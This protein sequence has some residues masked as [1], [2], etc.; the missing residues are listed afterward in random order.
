ME[1]VSLSLPLPLRC[2]FWLNPRA[3][4]S[5]AYPCL[6][7]PAPLRRRPL[8]TPAPIPASS[9]APPD[10]LSEDGALNALVRQQLPVTATPPA[11]GDTASED[12]AAAAQFYDANRES[13]LW[14]GKNGLSA[15]AAA[16]IDEIKK[17]A[18][19]G[20]EPKEFELPSLGRPRQGAG[21]AR[22]EPAKTEVKLTLAV[23]KYARHARGGRISEPAKQLSSYLDRAPQL[24]IRRQ[25]SPKLPRPMTR[26]RYVRGLH[27]KHAAVR[28]TETALSRAAEGCG[29]RVRRGQ[30]SGRSSAEAWPEAPARRPLASTAQG[31]R[32]RRRR[33]TLRSGAGR[34][35][36]GL[37]EGERSEPRRLRR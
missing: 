30:N 28:E 17:A 13:L 3:P 27:P 9:I 14:V 31:P 33:H 24:A 5:P 7:L 25:S 35:R 36:Q 23:L 18:D 22:G 26:A 1:C 2:S 20:L 11:A 19:W 29:C 10:T 6:H 34:R 15:K 8:L 37:P 16:A 21:E 32:R 4:S 12:R